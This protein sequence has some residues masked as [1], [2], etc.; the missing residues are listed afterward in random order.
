MASARPTVFPPVKG[1]VNFADV[2]RQ[3]AAQFGHAGRRGGGNDDFEVGHARLQGADELRAEVDFADADGMQPD[4]LAVG[5]RLLEIPVVIAKPLE[6]TGKPVAA[7]PHPQEIIRR[8]QHEKNREQNVVKR[9][10]SNG[11]QD[12]PIF[13]QTGR[14]RANVS[15]CFNF[16]RGKK[17]SQTASSIGNRNGSVNLKINPGNVGMRIFCWS[18]MALTMKFGPLPM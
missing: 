9:A 3:P 6:K 12:R 5:Q 18:A 7:P 2:R 14:P 8:G 4:D 16:N 11:K 17:T 10:H 13:P 15:K 1:I